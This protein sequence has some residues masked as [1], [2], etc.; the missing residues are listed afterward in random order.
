MRAQS[1]RDAWESFQ[2][3]EATTVR[4]QILTSWRRARSNGI[5]PQR[6]ELTHADIDAQSPFVRAAKP[7]LLKMADLLVGSSTSL[8]LADADGTLA[9]R[10]E[11]ERT[12]SRALDRAEFEP[13]SR[14]GEPVAGTN[15]IGMAQTTN[16]TSLVIGAEHYKEPWHAWACAASPVMDPISRRVFGTV[17]VACRAEDANHLLQVAARTLVDGITTTLRE[18]ATARQRRM[19]NTHLSYCGPA[20]GPVVTIDQRTMIVDNAPTELQLDRAELWSIVV[21]AGPS[22]TEVT[23]HDGWSARLHPVT[24]GRLH[25]GVVLVLERDR[26]GSCAKHHGISPL[27]T[28]SPLEQAEFKVI[29]ETLAECGGNKSEA[30]ARLGISRGTLYHRVRRYR[31]G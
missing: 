24:Q 1:T 22:A 26:R 30:A 10:W 18:A 7:V 19:L 28:L 27:A 23:L 9:W 16:R 12:L 29:N 20:A 17:N 8:A 2:S 11:S 14:V 3:G 5:D 21:A 25:D 6:L 13:G 31:L 15:G 4:P